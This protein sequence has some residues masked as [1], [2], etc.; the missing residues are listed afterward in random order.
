MDRY[1]YKKHFLRHEDM[2]AFKGAFAALSRLQVIRALRIAYWWFVNQRHRLSPMR[3]YESYQDRVFDAK[4]GTDTQTRVDLPELTV[5]GPNMFR[6]VFYQASPVARTR[7]VI[8]GLK[9]D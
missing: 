6:G 2:E 7:S 5:V 1:K 4:Y 3:W 9:I 8:A